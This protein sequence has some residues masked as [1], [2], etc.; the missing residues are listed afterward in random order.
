MG[1]IKWAS[2]AT[3]N[4]VTFGGYSATKATYKAAVTHRCPH[5]GAKVRTK[6]P[7]CSSCGRDKRGQPPA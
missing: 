5:C 7:I 4:T 1:F 2:K 6:Y 3:A